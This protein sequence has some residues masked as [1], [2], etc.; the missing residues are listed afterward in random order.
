[1]G[2]LRSCWVAETSFSVKSDRVRKTK[3]VRFIQLIAVQRISSNEIALGLSL[4]GHRRDDRSGRVRSK[5]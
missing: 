5:K 3:E 1:V 2:T 4:C